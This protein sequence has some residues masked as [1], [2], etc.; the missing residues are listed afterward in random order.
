M[1]SEFDAGRYDAVAVIARMAR[2]RAPR[3]V[4]P[5]R[6]LRLIAPYYD[7]RAVTLQPRDARFHLAVGRAKLILGEPEQAASEFREATE[8]EPTLAE[9]HIA[10]ESCFQH[11]ER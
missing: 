4:E 8:R 7:Y 5:L 10:L 6:L 11:A 1:H 9:A 3:E 2:S